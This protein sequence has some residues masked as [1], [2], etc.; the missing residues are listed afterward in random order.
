MRGLDRLGPGLRRGNAT[1][2]E[3]VADGR[4]LRGPERHGGKGGEHSNQGIMHGQELD[5]VKTEWLDVCLVG[6]GKWVSR[7]QKSNQHWEQQTAQVREVQ[8][9]LGSMLQQ[10]PALGIPA[11]PLI[12][13]ML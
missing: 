6:S 9:R 10:S 8:H 2:R 12:S 1:W 13:L 5:Q 7:Q 11:S 3:V 4:E